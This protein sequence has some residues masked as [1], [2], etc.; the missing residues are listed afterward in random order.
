MTVSERSVKK[1]A[2]TDIFVHKFSVCNVLN[3]ANNKIKPNLFFLGGILVHLVL[4]PCSYSFFS[5]ELTRAEIKPFT[6]I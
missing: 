6:N 2:Q 4:I 5:V 3:V 1:H